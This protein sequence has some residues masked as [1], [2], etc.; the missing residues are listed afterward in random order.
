M[1]YDKNRIILIGITA[2]LVIVLAVLLVIAIVGLSNQKPGSTTPTTEPTQ[3][4]QS[5]ED[6]I[7][8]TPYGNIVFPGKH[9]QY[10][11]VERTEQP[12]LKLEFIAQMDSGKT[13]KLF[14]LRFGEAMEPAVGQVVS[15]EGVP[16]GVYVTVY[17]F[18]PDGTW[19]VRESTAVSEMLEAVD[20][21]VASLNLSPLGTPIPDVQGEELVINTPY[22]KL[23]FPGQWAEELQTAV[24]ETDGYEIIFSGIINGHEPIK[25]FAVN[26]GGSEDTGKTVHTM[27]TENE[28]AFH[29]RLR[30]FTLETEGWSTVDQA[31]A[32]AM[33]EDLNHLLT[34]LKEE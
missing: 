21:V 33:Q 29:V 23:Y 30:T 14:S 4:V 6:K 32:M 2:A 7:I 10:L 31:T 5:G 19:P 1:R 27:F 18:S 17:S 15:P 12:E 8:E 25:L 11:K 16:V 9:A 26:F 20:D 13:Q 28:V 34:K 3:E 22:C 24:D